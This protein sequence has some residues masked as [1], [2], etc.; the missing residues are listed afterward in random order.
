MCERDKETV[1][2][3]V[4]ERD[5]EMGTGR[6]R[7]KRGKREGVGAGEGTHRERKVATQRKE[8]DEM[9]PKAGRTEAG[10]ENMSVAGNASQDNGAPH[11]AGFYSG[12]CAVLAISQMPRVGQGF[13]L[14]HTAC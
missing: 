13:T 5:S 8:R 6:L 2:V 14:S 10:K 7:V 12:H 9:E 11:T 3:C 4:R 1:C